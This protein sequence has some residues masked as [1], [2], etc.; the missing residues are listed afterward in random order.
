MR[1]GSNRE[2]AQWKSGKNLAFLVA[3]D[4]RLDAYKDALFN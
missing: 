4:G 2:G 1:W 3:Q